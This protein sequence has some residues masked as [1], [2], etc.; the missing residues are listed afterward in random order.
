MPF[1]AH[2]A[3]CVMLVIATAPA[4]ATDDGLFAAIQLPPVI[5]RLIAMPQTFQK[6]RAAHLGLITR[7]AERTGLP[8]AVA[9]AV[10]HV[11]SRFNPMAVGGVGEVGLMQIRPQTAAML[12]YKGGVTGLFDPETNVHFGVKYLAHAW[13]LAKGDLCRALMKYRA[14]WGEERMSPLS[15][16]YCRR[17]RQH[18]AAIGSPLGD[19]AVPATEP[20]TSFAERV[21]TVQPGSTDRVRVASLGSVEVP[22]ALNFSQAHMD[23]RRELKRAR[24]Q[25]RNG[26]RTAVDT[27]RYW[28]AHEARIREIKTKLKLR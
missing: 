18:L 1:A 9:D 16:E 25:A 27:Q 14:G 28:A 26:T 2:A 3:A 8:V 13:T 22:Q 12:G 19:G 11:E 24:S 23:F 7:E 15:A 5:D 4:R 6:G 10:I 20:S 17:A 21:P